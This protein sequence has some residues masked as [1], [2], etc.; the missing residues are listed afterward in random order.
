VSTKRKPTSTRP[1]RA[2]QSGATPAVNIV[3][4]CNR[5]LIRAA[6]QHL[7]E[8]ETRFRVIAQADDFRGAAAL[9]GDV[10]ADAVVLADLDDRD[11]AWLA[12]LA[13]FLMKAE[14][15]KT[16]L[17]AR[18]TSFDVHSVALRS[19]ARGV[20]SRGASPDLFFKAIDKV[21]AG[22]VW[23]ERSMMARVLGDLSR[24]TAAE[25]GRP[26]EIGML[27]L[28]ER[29]VVSLISEGLRN[30]Q[31]ADRLFISE[32]TVRHHLTSIFGKLEVKDR[33]ALAVYAFRYG[34]SAARAV[35]H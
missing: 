16:L 18:G 11:D 31:I 3:L 2:A 20:L 10:I 30:R 14:T 4:I 12:G 8:T 5:P 35:E 23:V 17:L 24:R 29:E 33:T 34:L 19:G 27:T 15:A 22:E 28:R 6:L 21:A 26:R 1:E 25:R 13:E 7:I 32:T 9:R